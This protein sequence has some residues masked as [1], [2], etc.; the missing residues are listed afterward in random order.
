MQLSTQLNYAGGFKAGGRPG[1]RASRRPASTWSG[2]PRPTASTPSAVMGYLAAK[3]DTVQ[4][5]VGHPADLH[6]HARRC[7]P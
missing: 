4:I 1:R 6:P 5:A 2:W 7:S 3:T